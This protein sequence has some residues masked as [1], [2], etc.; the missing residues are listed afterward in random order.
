MNTNRIIWILG[1][2]LGLAI[3]VLAISLPPSQAAKTLQTGDRAPDFALP[4]QSGRIIKLADYRGRKTVV[5]AF[6]IKAS[7]PG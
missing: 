6:Y 7:T 3:V 5:L 2:L 1:I 4:D